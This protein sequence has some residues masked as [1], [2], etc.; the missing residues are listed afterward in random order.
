MMSLGN[1]LCTLTWLAKVE[2]FA[3][4]GRILYTV[5]QTPLA[6]QPDERTQVTPINSLWQFDG[7]AVV[8]FTVEIES[9]R[10]SVHQVFAEAPKYH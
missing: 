3:G 10:Y 6:E 1:K 5:L 7:V 8:I 9:Q 4:T 2:V